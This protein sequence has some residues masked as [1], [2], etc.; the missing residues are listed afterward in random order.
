M[1]PTLK[2]FTIYFNKS[3]YDFRIIEM[4]YSQKKKKKNRYNNF[5]FLWGMADYEQTFL[6]QIVNRETEIEEEKS[7]LRVSLN[8]VRRKYAE[9]SR[10]RQTTTSKPR[11]RSMFQF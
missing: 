8:K 1:N 11:L 6:T 9:K 2:I 5:T 4:K 10:I 7:S 3:L